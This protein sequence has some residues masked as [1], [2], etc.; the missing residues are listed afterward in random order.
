M[1]FLIQYDRRAGQIRSLQAFEDAD[2][3]KAESGRLDMEL[4]GSSTDRAIEIVLL[5][6]RSEEDLRGTH[7]RYFESARELVQS[8]VD[9]GI[10]S[11]RRD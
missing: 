6:A 9:E 11:S 8:G 1:I 2:R 4:A 3:Q 7:R 5:E 10:A